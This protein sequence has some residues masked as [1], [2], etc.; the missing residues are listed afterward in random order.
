MPQSTRRAW[1]AP[2][3][4]V[5]ADQFRLQ[6]VEPTINVLDFN[7]LTFVLSDKKRGLIMK[8]LLILSTVICLLCACE[9]PT[10]PEGPVGPA[11]P[12]GAAGADGADGAK[13][14]PGD[15]GNSNVETV[16][17]TLTADQFEIDEAGIMES[18]LFPSTLV[19]EDVVERGAVLAYTD[20]GSD[21]E[22]WFAMPFQFLG[23]SI[24][25]GFTVDFLSVYIL[26][27]PLEPPDMAAP[28]F[29]SHQVRFVIFTPAGAALLK[30][31]NVD[32][33]NYHA[34]LNAVGIQ[35]D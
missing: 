34:V 1:S 21:G 13:G 5:I 14:D 33:K 32:I 35:Q 29:D 11:G 10:G 17:V 3:Y 2:S 31:K 22:I 6:L 20:L 16:T 8:H 12:V 30:D 26:H 9:G 25:H 24:S 7:P 19:T 27:P 18:A 23:I 28:L 4:L 15:P